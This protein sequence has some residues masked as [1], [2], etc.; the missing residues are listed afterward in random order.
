MLLFLL[1]YLLSGLFF[2]INIYIV[3][4]KTDSYTTKFFKLHTKAFTDSFL[5]LMLRYLCVKSTVESKLF[6]VKKFSK[7]MAQPKTRKLHQLH[8]SVDTDLTTDL[9]PKR[10][11]QDGFP[12]VAIAW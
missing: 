1:Q 11:Y 10:R 4:V 3:S 7:Y 9:L 8:N 12:W 5:Q 2:P 6:Y